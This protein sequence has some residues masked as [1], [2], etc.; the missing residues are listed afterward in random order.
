MRQ[1]GITAD[2]AISAFKQASIRREFP[3]QFLD[4]TL[5][6]IER[7]AAG[8]DRFARTALKLLFGNEYNK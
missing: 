6:E 8:R 3:S 5:D 1:S 7:A 4:K 2:E